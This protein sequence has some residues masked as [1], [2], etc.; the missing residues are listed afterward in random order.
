MED[1]EGKDKPK[2][3]SGDET[4]E[5]SAT[6]LFGLKPELQRPRHRPGLLAIFSAYLLLVGTVI[7]GGMLASYAGH[8]T[9]MQIIFYVSVALLL[10]IPVIL[11]CYLAFSVHRRYPFLKK[12]ALFFE[13][14][15]AKIL[16][17]CAAVALG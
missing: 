4:A 2:H 17:V 13:R 5:Q 11:V 10:L 16:P 15:T 14:H 1:Q 6:E 8:G 9:A 3:K 7:G 12:I